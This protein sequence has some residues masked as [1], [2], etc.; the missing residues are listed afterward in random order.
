LALAALA[1]AVCAGSALPASQI[2]GGTAIQI[3]AAPWTVFVEQDRSLLGEYLCTGSIIDARHIV[4]A[5]HCVFDDRGDRAKPVELSVK[6]GVSNF[7]T[8]LPTDAEQDRSVSALRVHPGYHWTGFAASDDVAVLTLSQPLHLGGKDV[9]A[10]HL[11]AAKSAFPSGTAVGVGGFGRDNPTT[12]SS[13]P[14]TWM[15]ATI[16]PQGTCPDFQRFGTLPH[17]AVLM[18]ASALT[19]A[20]CSGD[21]GSALVTIHGRPTLL[22]VT[23]G[24]AAGCPE[25]SDGLFTYV[26][27]PEILRFLDGDAHPP[28]SPRKHAGTA[29]KLTWQVPLVAGSTVNCS[30]GTWPRQGHVTY[31]FLLPDGEVAQHGSNTSF[32]IPSKYV[33]DAITCE[34]AVTNAGG[35]T[36][37]S[38]RQSPVVIEPPSPAIDAIVPV[39]GAAG[40]RV[41]LHVT[42]HSPAGL[43]GPV[44]V[45]AVP[46]AAV[47]PRVC[48]APQ[49]D[50][51]KAATAP[52]TLGVRIAAGAPAGIARVRLEV[53]AGLSSATASVRLTVS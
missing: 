21:S 35:T 33:Y 6:A 2:V 34:V 49:R 23:D 26:G 41:T 8:P 37:D 28:L 29:V 36:L 15:T 22:G 10:L 32:V 51:G 48:S 12:E 38:S 19:A 39:A 43:F 44:R 16:D 30:A 13:G 53:R 7:S 52:F 1:G 46:P 24:G 17:N 45:C 31:L 14:L 27:A 3:Q 47:G 25:G 4:T 11:P 42:V 5:A 40:S 20:V 50:D 18:C 9:R